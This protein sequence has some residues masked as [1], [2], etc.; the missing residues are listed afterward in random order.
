ML[1]E[2]GF[3]KFT[4]SNPDPRSEFDDTCESLTDEFCELEKNVN[5]AL[6]H[7]VVEHF[8]ETTEPL[9]RLARAALTLSK[10]W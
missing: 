7:L 4:R 2:N 5:V 1:S 3:N 10:V 8:A 6:L 9:D